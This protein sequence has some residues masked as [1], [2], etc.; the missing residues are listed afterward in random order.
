VAAA[1]PKNNAY[2]RA[3]KYSLVCLSSQ[4]AWVVGLLSDKKQYISRDE[5]PIG[6]APVSSTDN[7]SSLLGISFIFML[8]E[9]K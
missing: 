4:N 7:L 9:S 6:S 3:T 1:G 8:K 2:F 5:G